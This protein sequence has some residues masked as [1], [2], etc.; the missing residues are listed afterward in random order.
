MDEKWGSVGRE[1]QLGI[2]DGFRLKMIEEVKY[3]SKFSTNI[4]IWAP[5]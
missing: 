4:I 5:E 1:G 3:F 2:R